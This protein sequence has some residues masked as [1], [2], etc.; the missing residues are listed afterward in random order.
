M[1][2]NAVTLVF[3]V[4]HNVDGLKFVVGNKACIYCN[5]KIMGEKMFMEGEMTDEELSFIH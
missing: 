4:K 2:Q 1:L 3:F 5:E